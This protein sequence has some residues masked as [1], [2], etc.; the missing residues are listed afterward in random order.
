MSILPPG[1]KLPTGALLG[2]VLYVVMLLFALADFAFSPSAWERASGA[3]FG[4]LLALLPAFL[5]AGVVG[6][7][8]GRIQA[9]IIRFPLLG[10]AYG[11]PVGAFLQVSLPLTANVFVVES[12]T[13]L[14]WI[15]AALYGVALGFL[16]GLLLALIAMFRSNPDE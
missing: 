7:W 5:A 3:V 4:A 14:T 11:G 1:A 2:A 8:L 9:R 13:R 16:G 6:G 12:P 10:A 15:E